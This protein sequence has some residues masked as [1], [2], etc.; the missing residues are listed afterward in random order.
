MWQQVEGDRVRKNC[1][2]FV[3]EAC[4]V[5]AAMAARRPQGEGYN[6]LGPCLLPGQLF[7]SSVPLPET[8]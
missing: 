6:F 5:A 4:D 1:S 8:A 2:R 3:C 7:N